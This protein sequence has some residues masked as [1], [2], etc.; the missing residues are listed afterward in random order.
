M[1][2]NYQKPAAEVVEMKMQGVL[3]WSET[4]QSIILG[5]L[6][7]TPVDGV[8]NYSVQNPENWD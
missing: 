5:L 1:K 3:C 8:E 2:K 7:A 6:N 4:Q